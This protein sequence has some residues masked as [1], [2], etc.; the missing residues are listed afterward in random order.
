MKESIY[1]VWVKQLVE[2]SAQNEDMIKVIM[3]MAFDEPAKII[4]HEIFLWQNIHKYFRKS[5]D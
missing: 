1:K 4:F 3:F 2:K 5:I